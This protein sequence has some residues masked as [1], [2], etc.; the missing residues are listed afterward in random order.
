LKTALVTGGT[1]FIGGRLVALLVARGVDV[2]ALAR[3]REGVDKVKAV[4]ATPIRG[5][6]TDRDSMREPMRGCDVVFHVASMYEVGRRH[7]AQ[8]EKVNVEG[9]RAVLETALEAGVPKMVFTSTA[10]V[11]GDT[12]G[13][14]VDETDV[15]RG[16]FPTVYERTKWEAHYQVVLPMIER[17][18]PVVIV[19]WGGAFGPADHS[20]MNDL[21]IEHVRGRLWMVPGKET[22]FSYAYVDDIAEGH[23]LAAEKGR[24]GES[25]LIA[26][27]PIPADQFTR[28]WARVTGRRAPQVMLPSALVRIWWPLVDLVERVIRLPQMYS[29]EAFRAAGSTWIVS[30]EKARRELG[31]TFRPVEEG[32]KLTFDWLEQ[33]YG[34]K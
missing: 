15:Y 6:V 8:M 3:S 33:R 26:G 28:M 12:K 9:T 11:L 32:L 21:M 19:L 7:K 31:Y 18:A 30:S 20:I 17:G 1:G 34:K 16:N 10:A 5:D 14:V 25:Y 24:P 29:A 22:T 2:R 13:R 23:I 4:G 27:T